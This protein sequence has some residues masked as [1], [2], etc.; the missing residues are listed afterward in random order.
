MIHLHVCELTIWTPCLSA[1]VMKTKKVETM[2][3][4]RGAIAGTQK[5]FLYFLPCNKISC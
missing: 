1:R 4:I 2:T 3:E 5:S